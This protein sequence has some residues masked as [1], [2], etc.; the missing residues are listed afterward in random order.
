ML[1]FFLSFLVKLVV[2]SSE[3]VSNFLGF[4]LLSMVY[5]GR[6]TT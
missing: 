2:Y 6:I 5:S 1:L 4:I 3:D